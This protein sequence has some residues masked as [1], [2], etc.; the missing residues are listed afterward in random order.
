MRMMAV[1]LAVGL[2]AAPAVAQQTPLGQPA[3]T[4]RAMRGMMQR[5][6]GMMH[7]GMAMSPMA[8]PMHGRGFMAHG[9]MLPM[10]GG[11]MPGMMQGPGMVLRLRGALDLSDRQVERLEAIHESARPEMQGHMSEAMR[12]FQVAERLLEPAAPDLE[13][14]RRGLREAAE[15]M[16]LAHAAMASADVRAREVLT[17]QQRQRLEVARDVMREMHRGCMGPGMMR[18]VGPGGD[19]GDVH[20]DGGR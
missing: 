1:T 12:A 17:P 14:Y 8:C 5:Q 19:G 6:P 11:V 10:M 3:D 13:A 4:S 16:V 9:G 7:P 15:H 20:P 18:G 2:I